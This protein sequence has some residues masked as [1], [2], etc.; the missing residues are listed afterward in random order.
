VLCALP[1]FDAMCK[2]QGKPTSGSAN[3]GD[4]ILIFQDHLHPANAAPS[5]PVFLKHLE[6][7]FTES[8][9]RSLDN[10]RFPALA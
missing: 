4:T 8:A 10:L 7:R 1:A 6:T 5:K 3:S 9:L 2:T